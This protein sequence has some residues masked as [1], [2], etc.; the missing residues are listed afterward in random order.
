MPQIG[1]LR[2]LGSCLLIALSNFQHFF[3]PVRNDA[4]EAG[5]DELGGTLRVVDRVGPGFLAELMDLG[6]LAAADFF[7]VPDDQVGAGRGSGANLLGVGW[8]A[9]ERAQGKARRKLA[10]FSDKLPV[11]RL[12]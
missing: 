3:R 2:P 8:L 7:V 9:A 4:V 11:E 5:G 1:L 12:D 6:D 10:T